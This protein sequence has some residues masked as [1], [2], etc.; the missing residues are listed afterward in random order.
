LL[1]K[2]PTKIP[3]NRHDLTRP[4]TNESDNERARRLV[5]FRCIDQ[6][7]EVAGDIRG[8]H[9]TKQLTGLGINALA[10]AVTIFT[11][12]HLKEEHE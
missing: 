9:G 11:N 1:P 8:V 6:S 2:K 5:D 4:D 12:Y 7:P 10:R 3:E